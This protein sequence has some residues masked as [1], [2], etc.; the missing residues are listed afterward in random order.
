MRGR[1][2]LPLLTEPAARAAWPR[3]VFVQ[4]S[5]SQAGRAVR[6]A[7]WKYGVTAPGIGG[8]Q[9]PAADWYAEQYLYD[10]HADRYEL[11]NLIGRTSHDAVSRR[12]RRRLLHH[13]RDDEGGE[14]DIVPAPSA[15]AGQFRVGTSE[16]ADL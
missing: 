8:G 6:T 16:L 10:L 5:E 11:H 13:L 3:D 14:P 9:Q 1:S 7:R 4:I 12:L 2:V 15:P